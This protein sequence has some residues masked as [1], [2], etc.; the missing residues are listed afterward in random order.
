MDKHSF[1]EKLEYS[2]GDS[3]TNDIRRIKEA[4][5]RCIKV[6]K[7]NAEMD[8]TGVD[9][10][11]TLK[12]GVTIK[13]DAKTREAHS[14]RYWKNGE[15]ELAI[16]TWSVYDT[17]I[18]WTGNSSS[19]VEYILYTFDPSD[20]DKYYLIPFQLL[21]TAARRNYQSWKDKYGEKSQYSY[22]SNGIKWQSKCIFVPASVVIEA[23]VQVMVLQDEIEIA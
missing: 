14:S 20:T 6:E 9:Y 19:P 1:V 23:L 10:I 2:M 8:K 22:G 17:K 21:R 4:I 7:T 13:I 3:I 18:G 11:A 16:E 12:S 5:D 15:P